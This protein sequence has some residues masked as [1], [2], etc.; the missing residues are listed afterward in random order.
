MLIIISHLL[1]KPNITTDSRVAQMS[2]SQFRSTLGSKSCTLR[3]EVEI[4]LPN[5]AVKTSCFHLAERSAE[6]DFNILE[7]FGS[8]L[9]GCRYSK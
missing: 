7:F 2:K 6:V 1:A 3:L 9:A 4:H 5:I 8:N